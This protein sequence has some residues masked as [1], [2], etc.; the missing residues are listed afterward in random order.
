L[1]H[2][3][4]KVTKPTRGANVLDRFFLRILTRI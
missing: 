4:Q 1:L 2:F 3:K